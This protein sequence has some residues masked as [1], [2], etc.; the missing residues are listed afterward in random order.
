[1]GA[2]LDH[3]SA[4]S[5]RD[6]RKLAK[7]SQEELAVAAGISVSTLRRFERGDDAIGDYPKQ[8]LSRALANEGIMVLGTRVL[9]LL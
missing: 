7:L 8:Q 4:R 6:A 2:E 3:L 1:M 5:C 9:Q